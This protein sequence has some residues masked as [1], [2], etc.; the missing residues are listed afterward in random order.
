VALLTVAL[1]IGAHALAGGAPSG[2]GVALAVVLAG[3]VGALASSTPRARGIPGLIALLA[4]GQL[5]CHLV[6]AAA[7]HAHTGGGA[8]TPVMVGAHAAAV[9]VGA[10]LIAAGDRL[11][12][13]LST[14]VRALTV[15]GLR[16]PHVAVV[17]A[18]TADQPLQWMLYLRASISH[19][20]PPVGSLS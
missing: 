15:R 9:V 18:K 11:C 1:S 8:P 5:L 10:V 6:L 20:G 7:G 12:R 4:A 17:A 13:A 14:V 3:T 16:Q 2:A 19:R